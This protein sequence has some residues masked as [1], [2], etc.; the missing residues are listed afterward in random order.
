MNELVLATPEQ[1]EVC[2][3]I[4]EEA[5]HFQREQGF[6]QWTDDYPN[7]DTIR[8]DI[9]RA[10]GYVLMAGGEVAAYLCVDFDGEPA[11]QEIRGAWHTGEDYAVVHRL[12]FDSRFRGRGMAGETFCLVEKLCRNKQVSGIRVDTDSCN[13]RMQ[14]VL[15]KCGFQYCGVVVFQ[16]SGKVAYDK[17]LF[18]ETVSGGNA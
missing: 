2:Y 18:E 16:G 9:Q 1:A 12:A 17:V 10:K 6:V 7:L 3:G 8:Y 4:I 5:K 15:E 13:Q 14:H 11:Y